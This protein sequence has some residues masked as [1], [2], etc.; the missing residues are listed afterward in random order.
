MTNLIQ[1]DSLET[2]ETLTSR[3]NKA[4]KKLLSLDGVT[5]SGENDNI[6][7]VN[8]SLLDF[9][10]EPS[11][12]NLKRATG[13]VNLFESYA[14]KTALMGT[15]RLT[16]LPNRAAFEEQMSVALKK[17]GTP[18][19]SSRGEDFAG[20]QKRQFKDKIEAPKNHFAL[21]FLDLDRFKGL[22]DD[23]GH[24]TGDI[25][26]QTFARILN[27]IVRDDKDRFFEGKPRIARLGG[28]EFSIILSTKTSSHEEAKE[29]FD[30]ALM[31]I[32][33]ELAVQS[34][35][36]GGKTFPLVSSCG[37]HVI[38]ESDTAATVMKKADKSLYKHK[39][40]LDENK[41]TKVERYQYAT[42]E[43]KKLGLPNIQNIEDKRADELELKQIMEIGKAVKTLKDAGN[44][45]IIVSQEFVLDA[46]NTLKQY[47]I[48]MFSNNS[49]AF[50]NEVHTPI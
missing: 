21:V 43:L 37:L 14:H 5:V 41:L 47:D 15:D 19:T 28:D 30:K 4:A 39:T 35:E 11:D 10:E 12:K 6:V 48:N 20:P 45:A 38:E 8:D 2:L 25:G 32:R 40:G 7:S 26:L 36:H 18:A 31:R 3:F 49:N 34:F 17:N 16:Q 46:V 9:K 27:K 22:N 42:Q 24:E 33:K 23:H 13:S 1:T 44:V 50:L 29:V